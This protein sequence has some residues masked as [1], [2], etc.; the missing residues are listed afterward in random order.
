M[1]AVN[2]DGQNQRSSLE[3]HIYEKIFGFYRGSRSPKHLNLSSR[4]VAKP[5]K[6]FYFALI[7]FTFQFNR[8]YLD[9]L[10]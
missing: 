1:I 4:D 8:R 6:T 9:R 5:K 7:C 3:H 2:V 10:L